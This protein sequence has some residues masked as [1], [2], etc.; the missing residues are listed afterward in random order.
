MW[1][2]CSIV[3]EDRLNLLVEEVI[4]T[5]LIYHTIDKIALAPR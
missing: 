1:Q 5:W 3:L 2:L 4:K